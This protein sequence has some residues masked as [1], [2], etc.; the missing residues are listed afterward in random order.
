MQAHSY[1]HGKGASWTAAEPTRKPRWS[2]GLGDADVAAAAV[3][4]DRVAGRVVDRHRAVVV[5]AAGVALD[6]VAGVAVRNHDGDV[7]AAA[8]DLDV[9]RNRREHQGDIPAAGTQ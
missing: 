5:A 6:R 7:A 9:V 4:L 3:H 2:A 8:V 1:S